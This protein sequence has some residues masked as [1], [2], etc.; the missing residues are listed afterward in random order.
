MRSTIHTFLS[1]CGRRVRA[2][3][4]VASVLLVAGTAA[5]AKPSTPNSLEVYLGSSSTGYTDVTSYLQTDQYGE[6]WVVGYDNEPTF[7]IY[8]NSDTGQVTDP[9]NNLIGYCVSRL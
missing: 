3:I 5:L 2:I 7:E 4:G 9:F 8:L 6:V 1:Y